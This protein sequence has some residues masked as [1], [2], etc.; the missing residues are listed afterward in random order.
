MALH[1]TSV[2]RVV[3]LTYRVT[4][5]LPLIISGANARKSEYTQ[6]FLGFESIAYIETNILLCSIYKDSVILLLV[7]PFSG[8]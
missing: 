5:Y 6:T 2:K 7:L 8:D 4:P 3:R 1:K